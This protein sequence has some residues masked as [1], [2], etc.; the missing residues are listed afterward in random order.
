MNS[1]HY[2]HN[3]HR[4]E[5]HDH[6]HVRRGGALWV[7]ILILLPVLPIAAY[8]MFPSFFTSKISF[9]EKENPVID[10]SDLP[11]ALGLGASPIKVKL[12]DAGAGL[13]EVVVRVIQGNQSFDVFKE[14]YADHPGAKEITFP[15]N[16]KELGLREGF[17][18]LQLMVFDASFWSNRAEFTK[19][20]RI[21]YVKPRVE[22][23]TSQH[24]VAQGGSGLVFYRQRAGEISESGIMVG[25]RFYRGFPAAAF[26]QEFKQ[27]PDVYGV[28]FAIPKDFNGDVEKL[29]VI[30]RDVAGNQALAPMN[31][32]IL[33]RKFK[34]S[35]LKITSTYVRAKMDE[36]LPDYFEMARRTDAPP[37]SENA[38]SAELIRAFRTI[39]E[40]YRALLAKRL[41]GIL[42]KPLAERLWNGAFS[43][44]IAGAPTSSFGDIRS[45]EM[46]GEAAGGSAHDGID[47]AAVANT[48]V[49]P[50][51]RGK[52]IYAEDLGIY[53]N[54][55]IIDHGLGLSTLY[56]HL[57]SV[58]VQAGDEVSVD[59]VIGRSGATGLA[60]G[61]HLHFEVRV[62]GMSVTPIEWWDGRW[63]N[64]H[65]LGR[66]Q[67]VKEQMRLAY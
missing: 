8:L 18:S 36:L 53:G 63:V 58:L 7:V 55:V 26:D 14:K 28:F 23:L 38:T 47:L 33:K 65:I 1:W 21:V 54:T 42:S 30:A 52:V 20:I 5:A 31:Y 64:D 4:R 32:R 49:R 34:D 44:A 22:V 19:E 59:S 60:G 27:W 66:I 37:S 16:A 9:L 61:D 57:S 10:V 43:R 6:E 39:N 11:S 41:D 40:D 15:V 17:V 51:E 62:S 2:R 45:Y 48:Q 46:D 56:G 29:S 67:Q 35:K 12:A 25:D 13:D 24:N 3:H 50:A